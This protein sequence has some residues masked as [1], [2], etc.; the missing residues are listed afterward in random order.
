MNREEVRA[1]NDKM[2]GWEAAMNTKSPHV[3]YDTGNNGAV[4]NAPALCIIADLLT[5]SES[6]VSIIDNNS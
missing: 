2:L 1:A 4:T 3:D 5:L 6:F